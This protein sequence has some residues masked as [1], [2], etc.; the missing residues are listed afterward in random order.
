MF[1]ARLSAQP[2]FHGGQVRLA[3]SYLIKGR[4]AKSP[5]K[6]DTL[7]GTCWILRAGVIRLYHRSGKPSKDGIDQEATSVPQKK[8]GADSGTQPVQRC[9]ERGGGGGE[10]SPGCST[11]TFVGLAPFGTVGPDW[12]LAAKMGAVLV[13]GEARHGHL[14][15]VSS[16][17]YLRRQVPPVMVAFTL[18]SCSVRPEKTSP[19][20][21][22]A[23]KLR[24]SA[25]V[26]FP[27]QAQATITPSVQGI[28]KDRLRHHRVPFRLNVQS[29]LLVLVRELRGI[30]G[31]EWGDLPSLAAFCQPLTIL[32]VITGGS[33][34]SMR[35]IS[36]SRPRPSSISWAPPATPIALVPFGA[37]IR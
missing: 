6:W 33:P 36:V 1:P 11:V 26:W 18:A 37:R 34:G 32:Q 28:P 15:T 22:T 27:L 5:P 12:V 20:G 19:L 23:S 30:R 3:V 14:L 24:S 4:I 9:P 13:S 29:S 35:T 17:R 8:H 31:L 7:A 10:M 16:S 2:P 21:A 25:G